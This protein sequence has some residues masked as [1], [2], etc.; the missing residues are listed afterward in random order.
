MYA[1]CRN[2][3]Y[4]RYVSALGRV[5]I[6]SS[7]YFPAQNRSKEVYKAIC[8]R[9][10]DIQ[11]IPRESVKTLFNDMQLFPTD[12]E[13]RTMM[14]CVRQ[15]RNGP[16]QTLSFGEFCILVREMQSLQKP[17]IH[18]KS[19]QQKLNK[20]PK[21]K[22]EV[23]LG[24]SCNPTTWRAD[25]AIPELEKHGISFY[26][27]Q[28]SMWAPELLA[29]EHD[30]KQSASVLL[31]VIDSQ[32]RSTVGMLEVA[33]L[34]AS[35]RCVIVVAQPYKKGQSIMGETIS[36]KEYHDLVQGQKSLLDLIKS[37]GVQIHSNLTTALQCTA[38]ILKS[39][40]SNGRSPDEQIMYK[41]RRLREVYDSYNGQMKLYDVI[42][43]YHKLTNRSLETSKLFNYRNFQNLYNNIS[44][45][46]GTENDGDINRKDTNDT[47]SFEKF[48]VLMA[49]LS[50]ENCSMC[51][52]ETWATQ[53]FPRNQ[54]HA[55]DPTRGRCAVDQSQVTDNST[56]QEQLHDVYLGGSLFTNIPWRDTIA[57]PLLKKHG[58]QYYNPALREGDL[59]SEVTNNDTPHE[60]IIGWRQKID[61]SK[62]AL[63]VITNDTRS[64]TSM[65]TAA[66]YIGSGKDVVLCIE[67]LNSENCLVANERL[68]KTAI[69]DYNRARAYLRDVAERRQ[70]PVFDTPEEAV[71]CVLTKMMKSVALDQRNQLCIANYGR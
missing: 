22:C 49:E 54:C 41:L 26:N 61:Q 6:Y 59:S 48:C 62:I 65:I 31:F 45:P 56:N 12:N 40:S 3:S 70:V 64:L 30:A 42:G 39:A 68:T 38:E 16:N 34:V 47:I 11:N 18:R 4:N 57:I 35:G 53:G 44:R 29:Q 55:T 69:K 19:M 51:N 8:M 58:I 15:C 2:R 13:V 10:G 63:F 32:T 21:S 43:A 25:T 5:S 50:T 33:Y 24:G 46:N 52:V 28:V 7:C 1:L 60:D 66:H 14:Q 37:K 9:L 36:N 17:K 67:Q 71:R 27:P 20:C 23:F